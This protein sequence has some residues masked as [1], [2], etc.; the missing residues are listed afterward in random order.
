VEFLRYKEFEGSAEL[1]MARNVCRG[2]ILHI[3]DL[4]TYESKSV[5][6]L[7]KQFEDAVDDYV[8]T[9]EQV[10]KKAQKSCRGQFNVR[11]GPELHREAVRRSVYENISLNEVVC[12]ALS[13]YLIST[14][15]DGVL[16]VN[17]NLQMSSVGRSIAVNRPLPTSSPIYSPRGSYA[18]GTFEIQNLDDENHQ[19]STSYVG[20]GGAADELARV[21]IDRRYVN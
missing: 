8:E 12:R 20:T 7:Q 13:I 21:A 2:K 16:P 9:C 17:E 11:V 18:E 1:D 15:I 5:G 19:P 10:G 14:E 3:D 4:V 6:G